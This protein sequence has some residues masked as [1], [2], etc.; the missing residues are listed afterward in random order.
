M[1]RIIWNDNLKPPVGQSFI[2]LTKAQ[3]VFNV[4]YNKYSDTIV[5]GVMAS[6]E[7]LLKVH[8]VDYVAGV[9]TL[10]RPN[11]F[12]EIDE[13][14]N[15]HI[16]AANGALISGALDAINHGLAFAPVSGFHHAGYAN[17][18]GFCTFNGLCAAIAAVRRYAPGAKFL[19]IDGDGHYGNGT[20]DIIE[21]LG[22]VD[23]LHLTHGHNLLTDNW[24]HNKHVIDE[25]LSARP[26]LLVFYQAG[27]DAFIGDPYG[28]GY[29][30]ME[31]LDERDHLVFGRCHDL[32]LPLVWNL[33]GGY[34][35]KRTIL[36]HQRSYITAK[37]IYEQLLPE[38]T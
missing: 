37:G 9:L 11:G 27:A 13:P 12:G 35:G 28:A 22:W 14:T 3:S 2:S 20:Q 24:D 18:G 38:H 8:D 31:E 16:L 36:L 15:Q 34:D 21:R 7:N 6:A 4:C 30:T 1:V 26:W 33:A 29:M 23:V 10:A 5:P 17:G 19:I 25:A 32:K